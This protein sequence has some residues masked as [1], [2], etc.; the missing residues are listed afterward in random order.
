MPQQR[1]R[2]R[3]C[4]WRSEGDQIG[5]FMN[6]LSRD[7]PGRFVTAVV[8]EIDHER[9]YEGLQAAMRDVPEYLRHVQRYVNEDAAAT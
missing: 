6:I 8:D 3:F 2:D 7:G 1:H 9:V 4:P 5:Q